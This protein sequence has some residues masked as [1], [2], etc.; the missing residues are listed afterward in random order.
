MTTSPDSGPAGFSEDG[1]SVPTIGAPTD[2]LTLRE[3]LLKISGSAC[4]DFN[5]TYN[6]MQKSYFPVH[7]AAQLSCCLAA[8]KLLRQ[9]GSTSR[10][11]NQHLSSL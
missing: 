9:G 5:T 10:I 8:V 11:G 1:S 2:G 7:A 3:R 6:S 4:L